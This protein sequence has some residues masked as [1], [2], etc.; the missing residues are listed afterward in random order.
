VNILFVTVGTSGLT[1]PGIGKAPN[2]RDNT[3]LQ[4]E[5]LRYKQDRNKDAGRW[6]KLDRDLVAAHKA[7]WGMPDRFTTSPFNYLQT[8]AELTSTHCL[9]RDVGSKYPFDKIVLLP[10]ATAD[11]RMA[12]KVVLE[13]MRSPEYGIP[14]NKD[15]IIEEPIP[16]LEKDI[17]KLAAGL[18]EAVWKHSQFAV[19]KRFLN[20]TGGFKG[21]SLMLGRLSADNNYRIYYQHE[22]LDAAVYMRDLS[23]SGSPDVWQD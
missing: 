23:T 17:E 6:A 5:I 19:D 13:V 3:A 7:Y 21:T 22:T 15:S 1:N 11:G 9:I 14:L 18:R 10:T 12:S 8:A 16:G 2:G 4:A 20:V